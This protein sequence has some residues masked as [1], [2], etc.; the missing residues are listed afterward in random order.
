VWGDTAASALSGADNYKTYFD[1]NNYEP[2]PYPGINQHHIPPDFSTGEEPNPLAAFGGTYP[3]GQPISLTF[4]MR[5]RLND[6]NVT[7]QD[8]NNK[9]IVGYFR[10]PGDYSDP[11]SLYQGSS[12]SFIPQQPLQHATTY[13]VTVTGQRNNQDYKKE[14]QFR[15]E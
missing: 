2:I 14:W 9:N 1:A 7:L 5:E 6:F 11:N 8:E 10:M 15:T 13:K 4:P 3:A 12:I